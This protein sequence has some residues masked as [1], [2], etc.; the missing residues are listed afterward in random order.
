V[1]RLY[2]PRLPD[3]ASVVN[4]VSDLP[5]FL[6]Q[7]LTDET[8]GAE[9]A[10]FDRYLCILDALERRSLFDCSLL[11]IGCS[12]GFF[13]YLFAVSLCRQVT[14]VEDERG[15]LA[16]YSENAFLGPLYKAKQEYALRHL[17][18]ADAPIE[19]F[20]ASCPERQ[21]DVVLCLS[22]L[23]H[24]YTGYGDHP[25]RGRLTDAER[26]ALFRAIGRATGSVLYL[27]VDHGRVPGD[28]FAEFS[29]LGGFKGRATIGSSASAVGET[30]TLF[31]VWK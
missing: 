5:R 17:E 28:F 3:L 12:N 24:F 11:D 13:A 15:A 9:R 29:E 14:A 16:G 4:L 19:R 20:L 2:Q 21:W 7:D 1:E 6:G 26:R 23:H 31:E 10:C 22:V 18:I 8:V 27:E 25:D 30:R